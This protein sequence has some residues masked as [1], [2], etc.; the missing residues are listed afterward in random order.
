MGRE[1]SERFRSGSGGGDTGESPGAPR[2]Q[3]ALVTCCR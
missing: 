2:P 1:G 3:P